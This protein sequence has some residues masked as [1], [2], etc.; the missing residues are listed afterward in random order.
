VTLALIFRSGI[1]PEDTPSTSSFE[2][3]RPNPAVSIPTAD[4]ALLAAVR[5]GDASAFETIFRR[6]YVSMVAFAT[7]YVRDAEAA[8]ELV[9]E[10]FLR[11]WLRRHTWTVHTSIATYLYQSLRHR[12]VNA[13]R[14][15]D[16]RARHMVQAAASGIQMGAS[17]PLEKA[18]DA[19]VRH[20]RAKRV[21]AAV[22]ALPEP[23]RTIVWL[24]WHD[25]MSF[26]AIAEVV[27]STQAAVQMQ[28][29]RALRA[30]RGVLSES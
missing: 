7:P 17:T 4:V 14:Y 15:H 19:M 2:E 22:N 11:L 16:V 12:A 18:D 9:S 29:S 21:W 27:G 26:D 25:D 23:K 20:E 1:P 30:L 6:H 3:V 28:M 24:R 8:Q 13:R 5:A 10:I